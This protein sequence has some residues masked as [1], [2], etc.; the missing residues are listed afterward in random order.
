MAS[1]AST[2]KKSM[3][4]E[5]FPGASTMDPFSSEFALA[6][7]ASMFDGEDLTAVTTLVPSGDMAEDAGFL[8]G[9]GC[10]IYVCDEDK[11][12]LDEA[13]RQ[14]KNNKGELR[15]AFD[16]SLFEL[17]PWHLGTVD[18]IV[19]RTL[20]ASLEPSQRFGYANRMARCLRPGGRLVGLFRINDEERSEAPYA[21]DMK[22][23]RQS[24]LRYFHVDVF[25]VAAPPKPG[26]DAVWAACLRLK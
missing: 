22:E 14:V 25:R 17:K 9:K 24:V 6:W 12:K 20:L 16:K 15:G 23:F 19:D 5:L 1:P 10:E 4:P 18:L 21:T 13:K 8:A 26:D 11:A 3:V 7:Y 2:Q